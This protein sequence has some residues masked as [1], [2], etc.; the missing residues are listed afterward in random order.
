MPSDAL[1][2]G[3]ALVALT[4]SLLSGCLRQQPH[5]TRPAPERD[6]TQVGYG[7]LPWTAVTGAIASLDSAQIDGQRQRALTVAEL[8][9]RMPGVQVIRQPGGLSVRVRSAVGDALVVVDGTPLSGDAGTVL[10]TLR[11]AD[12]ERIDVLKD[13]GTAASYG[14]QGGS[15]V[16]LITTRRAR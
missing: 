12:V 6:T 2:R 15:G 16:V 9:E 10:A 7:A 13:A 3:V 1:G 5:A 4:V 14:G 8:L 11:A